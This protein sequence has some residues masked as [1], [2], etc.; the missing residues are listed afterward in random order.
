MAQV[1]RKF[2]NK[3]QR[4]LRTV[5]A[6]SAPMWA[7]HGSVPSGDRLL[8]EVESV[9]RIGSFTLDIPSERWMSSPGL[10]AIFGIDAAFERTV[11]DWLSLVHPADREAMAAYLTDE[12]LGHLRPFD[13]RYRIVRPDTGEERW[14][15]GRGTLE[16][17]GH[18]AP[19]RLFG[20]TA[21]ITEQVAAEEERA[22]L[23]EGLRRS[24][25][26]LAE[27]E[28][29]THIGSWE[30]DPA[31]DTAERSEETNRIFGVAPG[32]LPETNEAFLMFV[33]PDDRARLQAS[34]RATIQ[35][36]GPYG[37]DYRIVRPDGLVRILHEE[38]ELI[39]DEQGAP[40]WMGTVQDITERTAAEKEHSRLVS[41]VEHA[42]DSVIITGLAGTIEHVNPAF[43]QIS[44]YALADV[45]G[46]N[47][48]ILQSGLHSVAF[49]RALWRRLTRGEVWAGR[50]VNR[51]ADGQLYQVEAT[52]SPI[53][54]PG[55]QVTGYVGVERDVT[56]LLA[57]RSALAAE[58]RE[59]AEVAG[60]LC[61]L[62]ARDNAEA[63]ATGICDELVRL[64]DID[65]AAVFTFADPSHAA[66]LA[67]TGP[68]GLPLAAG[69]PLPTARARYLHARATKG[70]WAESWVPRPEDGDYGR[71]MVRVGVRAIAYAP[72]RNGEEL[73]GV[74]AAGT[75]NDMY[76][77]HLIDH[78]PIVSEFA[79]TAGALVA[80]QLERGRRE[81]RARTRIRRVLSPDPPNILT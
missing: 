63:T 46:Q 22:L 41:A 4:S 66:T 52:I 39:R 30:W 32:A 51:R 61:H 58:F 21:D 62:Q 24:A 1:T 16:L 50:F 9:A 60:S 81:D 76:A 67:V 7:A 2:A 53:R 23:I 72:I 37:L 12:V 28:R 55:G 31:A 18:G 17:D 43:E 54:D 26:R 57:A 6:T 27:A 10:D 44:G 3:G 68:E 48:R 65:L 40:V 15:Y 47:P 79:A 56:E 33:H 70:P 5:R 75:L 71:A 38:A 19:V 69:R 20:T 64:V 29:I 11:E 35:G 73:L 59:R 42:G 77:S 8:D 74:V 25:H 78:M 14:V 34:A 80:G 13:Q 36:G 49:Y 45:I